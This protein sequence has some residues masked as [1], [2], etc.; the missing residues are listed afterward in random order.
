MEFEAVPITLQSTLIELPC[1]S[2]EIMKSSRS[3]YQRQY[4]IKDGK[5]RQ[6][7]TTMNDNK[8]VKHIKVNNESV[9]NTAEGGMVPTDQS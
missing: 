1:L 2:N 3:S 7:M 8:T 4:D 6:K 5:K 9:L